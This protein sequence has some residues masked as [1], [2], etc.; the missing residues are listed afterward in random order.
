MLLRIMLMHEQCEQSRNTPNASCFTH[1]YISDMISLIYR[2]DTG[3]L[4]YWNTG[5]LEHS[6]TMRAETDRLQR[7]VLCHS[8]FCHSNLEGNRPKKLE[9]WLSLLL[10]VKPRKRSEV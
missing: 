5:T 1:Q 10:P 3:T 9:V 2:D 8:M 6:Q 4:E 7:H